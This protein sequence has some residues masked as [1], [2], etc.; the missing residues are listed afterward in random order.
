MEFL[1][2]HQIV[3]ILTNRLPGL[4]VY[5][6][7]KN[8]NTISLLI[9]D[10]SSQEAYGITGIEL[11]HYKGKYGAT[12]LAH[13][14]LEG[15]MAVRSQPNLSVKKISITSPL[16][17]TPIKTQSIKRLPSLALMTNSKRDSKPK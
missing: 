3:I 5:C 11:S 2:T 12:A 1:N 15:I 10:R 9:Q 17:F 16:F 13:Q 8:Q 6:T 7:T 4:D 14:L